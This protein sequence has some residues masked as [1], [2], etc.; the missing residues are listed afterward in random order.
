MKGWIIRM[1]TKLNVLIVTSCLPENRKNGLTTHVVQ[2]ANHLKDKCN[3]TILSTISRFDLEGLIFS[4]ENGINYL[5][6]GC[7]IKNADITEVEPA[8][9]SWVK[10]NLSLAMY[11][12][13]VYNTIS[14]MGVDV[15]HIHDYFPALS[16]EL[17][18]EKLKIPVVI[19]IH[20]LNESSKHF[21]EAMRFFL[22]QNATRIIAVSTY[23]KKRLCDKFLFLNPEKVD[24]IYNG[25]DIDDKLTKPYKNRQYITY[26]GRLDAEKGVDILINA[27]SILLHDKV[28]IPPVLIV[29]DGKERAALEKLVDSKKLGETVKFTGELESEEVYKLLQKTLINVLPSKMEQFPLSV[30]ESMANGANVVVSNI[31]GIPEIVEDEVNG[32][33]VEAGDAVELANSLKRLILDKQ[34]GEKLAQN[35]LYTIRRKCDWESI[36]LR[37][38]STYL[39][40]YHTIRGEKENGCY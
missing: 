23:T 28:M 20:A 17:F 15:V 29:G 10:A 9:C 27:V 5:D 35:A 6:I 19:T 34:L 37:T 39:R 32:L 1:V 8:A 31:G 38:I 36:A 4:K 33:L 16:I 25:V 3:L 11:W 24:V 2:L 21:G 14:K 7:C 12:D 30:I 18:R 13:D 40:A 26:I 22:M